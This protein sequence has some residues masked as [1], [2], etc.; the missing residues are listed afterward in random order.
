M[1]DS[2]LTLLPARPGTHAV[3]ERAGAG[4]RL[5][6]EEFFAGQ[7]RNPHTRRAYG[8]HVLAFLDS[9]Y[10]RGIELKHVSPGDAAA[11]IDGLAP[12][13][14]NQRMA[15]AALR[16]FF[17]RLVTRHAVLL[18]P[19]DS[20]QGP[21]RASLDGKTPEI[22]PDQATRLID[23]VDC[24][25]PVGVRDRAILGTLAGTGA[26]VGAVA[27][28]RMRDLRD[29]GEYRSLRFT[30]K[31]G[32][33]REIPLRLDLNQWIQAYLLLVDDFADTAAPLFRPLHANSR[34]RFARRFVTPY[35]I[36]AMLK[37]RL[38]D[39]GLP[40][41]I[42]PHSFRAM[43]V[44]DLLRQGVPM[45]DVQ[46][47]VGHS[48]PSTTQ[49]YD[50]RARKVTRNIVE[51]ISISACA[52]PGKGPVPVS[53]WVRCGGTALEMRWAHRRSIDLDFTAEYAISNRLPASGLS[54]ARSLRRRSAVEVTGRR[55]ERRRADCLDGR[56]G[57][58]G[59]R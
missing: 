4:A 20:V 25:R 41:I 46:Y 22:T 24:S 36:R 34:S 37:R 54:R 57:G 3:V 26:R 10:A 58:D 21:P 31:R 19:F 32:K 15:L 23:S 52:V 44:T 9:C 42:T 29:Y 43:V 11:F 38:A 18:N 33:E 48:H 12:S 30:E 55:W 39:A 53:N 8:R 56:E 5:A 28:L 16:R 49:I 35:T 14:S 17:D 59:R 27:K 40:R 13:V 50:R 7:L 2:A 51:R 1:S 6:A 47:L 45:E